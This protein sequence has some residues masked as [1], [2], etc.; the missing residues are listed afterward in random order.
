MRIKESFTLYKRK[1]PSGVLVFYYRTYTPDGKRTCG[2]STG[3][4]TKT[5]AREYCNKLLRDGKLHPV[6]GGVPTF[7]EFA[8]GWW[9]YESCPYLTKL[10]ARKKVA[11]GTAVQGSYATRTFL[12][13]TFGKEK[14]DTLTTYR[15]DAW[16]TSLP[17]SGY[18]NNTANLAFKFLNIMLGEAAL[19][20]KI[21]ANP[22][23]GIRLLPENQKEI[24]ILTPV[25]VKK[26]FPK[27]WQSI[28]RNEYIYII[29]K[30]AACTGMR[31]GELL[32]L[33]GEFLFE[34]YIN[35]CAQYNRYGYTDTKNHK[36]R[37]IPIPKSVE[38]DLL[39]LKLKNRDGYLFSENGGKN[40]LSRR[41]VALAL[42]AALEKTGID[43]AERK[44]RNLTFHGW[45]HFF[46]TTLLM[47]NV[48]D[49]KVMSLTG[50]GSEQM[51]KRYTHF[52][53]TQFAE[54]VEVQNTLLDDRGA[55]TD[56]DEKSVAPARKKRK[57]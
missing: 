32:G 6:K 42:N 9:D 3:Q 26:L 21:A 54:V 38:N 1:V 7:A 30:L 40:P 24:E 31:I 41:R 37:N 13:P 46:N 25:E 20:G 45:R 56:G 35:V 10:K 50:H 36:E 19:Q 8:A 15:I 18:A 47:A 23:H 48:P 12:I 51:K 57:G 2:Y 44:R 43:G 39:G 53:T 17:K 49:N 34:G 22:C 16:L 4:Q 11:Q 55:E 14:I 5:A 29:N 28:W 52:D 27:D 33:R